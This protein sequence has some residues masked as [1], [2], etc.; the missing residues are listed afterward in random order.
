MINNKMIEGLSEQ[1]SQLMQGQGGLPGQDA[2]R[3]QV[4]Q[5]LQSSFARM[6]LVSR[7]EFDAQQAVLTRTRAKLDQLE[8]QMAALEAQLQ[9]QD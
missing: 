4:R 8:Q 6:D 1:F 5:I 3:D 9:Q 2:V 7:E